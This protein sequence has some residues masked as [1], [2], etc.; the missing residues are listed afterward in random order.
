MITY[1][2]LLEHVDVLESR[3]DEY[4]K[5]STTILEA[6]DYK[7]LSELEV[8]LHEVQNLSVLQPYNEKE[9]FVR[10]DSIES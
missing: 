4:N 6:F 7:T 9:I 3:I 1:R 2:I 8:M 5:L 10:F